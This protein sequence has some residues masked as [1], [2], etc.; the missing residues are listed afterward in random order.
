[1]WAAGIF[2][3]FAWLPGRRREKFGFFEVRAWRVRRKI[4]FLL[5][6]PRLLVEKFGFF[7][8]KHEFL[9][10]KHGLLCVDP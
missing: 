1:L 7:V 3:F 4:E 9:G 8:K 2:G 5:V 10:R 6:P